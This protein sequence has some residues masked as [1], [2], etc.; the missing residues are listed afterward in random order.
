[1]LTLTTVCGSRDPG[2]FGAQERPP[3]RLT[4]L[5][6]QECPPALLFSAS[7]VQASTFRRFA[8]HTHGVHSRYEILHSVF[9]IRNSA[10]FVI[11]LHINHILRPGLLAWTERCDITHAVLPYCST[12]SA[13][14]L[15]GRKAYGPPCRIGPFRNLYSVFDSLIFDPPAVPD[16]MKFEN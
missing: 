10:L 6:F 16:V 7:L 3:A 9:W 12:I 8:R 15:A 1:M 2:E 4:T 5:N 14:L 11:R 13:L